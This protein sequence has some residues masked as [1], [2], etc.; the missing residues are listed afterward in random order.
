[1][2]RRT[3][4]SP[5]K[6]R[7]SNILPSTTSSCPT[8]PTKKPRSSPSPK[9]KLLGL[10]TPSTLVKSPSLTRS[11]TVQRT[12]RSDLRTH[13]PTKISPYKVFTDDTVY[14]TNPNSQI[15]SNHELVLSPPKQRQISPSPR[16]RVPNDLSK[17]PIFGQLQETTRSQRIMATDPFSLPQHS[18]LTPPRPRLSKLSQAQE[19]DR[20]T[21]SASPVLSRS[22]LNPLGGFAIYVDESEYFSICDT[23]FELGRDVNKENLW[24][25][26]C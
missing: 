9:K 12:T 7:S 16:K 5:K 2:D 25:T 3:A 8:S 14:A 1:M 6:L 24:R 19:E 18:F 20:L 22:C 21:K 17:R 11:D 26:V 23:S 4:L 13:S 15:A 10:A